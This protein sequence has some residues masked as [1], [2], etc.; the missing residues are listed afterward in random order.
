MRSTLK[1]EIEAKL[2]QL[3]EG[4]HRSTEE[5]LTEALNQTLASNEWLEKKVSE[6]V[7]AVDQGETVWNKEVR[8][9]SEPTEPES[10]DSKCTPLHISGEPFSAT[11]L[12]ERR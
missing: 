11:I 9:W 8:Q 6:S 10:A 2:N 3:A 7:A 1:S 12:R 5:V 4:T